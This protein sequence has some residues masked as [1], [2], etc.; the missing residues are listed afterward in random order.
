MT[1]LVTMLRAK[2]SNYY[3]LPSLGVGDGK[4]SDK[5]PD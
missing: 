4:S 3:I 1:M 5:F 2:V